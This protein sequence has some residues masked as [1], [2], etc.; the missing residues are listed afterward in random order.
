MIVYEVSSVDELMKCEAATRTLYTVCC[1]RTEIVHV[2]KF[3]S[4][5]K[6]EAVSTNAHQTGS[7]L[8]LTSTSRATGEGVR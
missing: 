8:Q 5:N 6:A 7:W 2:M 3:N 4:D 1:Q